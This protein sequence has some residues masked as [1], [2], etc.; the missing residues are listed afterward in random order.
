MKKTGIWI[1]KAWQLGLLMCFGCGHFEVGGAESDRFSS[2]ELDIE[3][4]GQTGFIV[5]PATETGIDFENSLTEIE[6]ARNRVLL[7]GSGVALGDFDGDGWVDIYLC[8]LNSA[9][10]LYRNLGGWRF[11]N[12]TEDAGV[13][14]DGLYCRGATMADVDGDGALDI[15]VTTVGQGTKLY[16]NQ[17][18]GRF[19]ETTREA[20]LHSDFGSSTLALADIDG[21]GT[22]DLYVSNYRSEDIRDQGRVNL[23]SRNGQLVVPDSFKQRLFLVGGQL[24]EYGEPDQLFLND[25]T[26]RFTNVDWRGGRF[27]DESGK[28]VGG[29]FPD[30]GLTASFRDVNGDL[31]PDLYVCNDYWSQD[32]FWINQGQGVFRAIA[33]TAWRSMSA[34]SMGVDFADI[35]LDGDLDFLTVDMLS[36]DPALRK[37]QKEAQDPRTVNPPGMLARPQGMRNMLFVDRGDRTY[38]EVAY[39]AGLEAS[40]WSW[41]PIFLDVDFDGDDDLLISA[42]HWRDVQDFDAMRAIQARQHSWDHI[43]DPKQLREAFAREMMIHNRL[44]PRLDMPVVAF[45]NNGK[46]RFEEVTES[47]GTEALGVRQG[48]ATGDLDNDGDLDVVA[49][50]LNGPVSVFENRTDR[51]RLSV[52]LH[53]VGSN[54]QSVG[55]VVTLDSDGMATQQREVVAGGHY[56]SGSDTRLVFAVPKG[57][58]AERLRVRWPDGREETWRGLTVNRHYEIHQAK[59]RATVSVQQERVHEVPIF[60]DVSKRLGHRHI[61][62]PFNEFVRQNL[63]PRELG[64]G[65]PGLA[66]SDLN[67]DNHLDLAVGGGQGQPVS[68]FFGNGQGQWSAGVATGT[69]GPTDLAGILVWR[70]PEGRDRLLTTV[71]G[72]ERAVRGIGKGYEISSKRV[73]AAFDF[74]SQMSS[75]GP[76][77]LGDRQGNGTLALF[78]GGGVAPGHYPRG[79]PSYL[80]DWHNDSWVVDQKN[81]VL[82]RELG[83]VNGA[84]WSDLDGD[85]YPELVLACEWGPIRVFKNRAGQLFDATESMGLSELTGWWRAVTAVDLNGDGAMDLVAS[86]WGWNSDYEASIAEPLTFFH[87]EISRPN[88]RDVIETE[89]DPLRRQRVPSR[90]LVPLATS[91]PFL[92]QTFSS[93]AEYSVASIETVL[94]ERQGLA[95]AESVTT[96]ASM[97]FLNEGDGFRPIVLPNPVQWAP[98]TGLA[99]GDFNG[100]GHEDVFMAQNYFATRPNVSRLDGGRG[101]LLLGDGT[102]DLKVVEASRSGIAAWGDQRAA[103]SGD[104]DEDGRI[105]LAVSQNRGETKLFHN[106]AGFPGLRVRLM[107]PPGNPTGLGAQLRLANGTN[108]GPAREIHGGS[109][110]WGQESAVVVLHGADKDA[111]VWVQWPGGRVANFEVPEGARELIIPF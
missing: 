61:D 3:A 98:A 59:E 5:R 42:G 89:M 8:G 30:W 37:R 22:L 58:R 15:L 38:A 31:R 88:V 83:I 104:W 21:N 111:S 2:R 23:G 75:G 95:R 84:V 107:G 36:R 82:L 77:A 110:Y 55:A 29:A 47:W 11:E 64:R 69:A 57:G 17:G 48:M 18:D 46:G 79:N 85:G 78:V 28:A 12:V 92:A 45:R 93:H 73:G 70:S 96:L 27:L 87:G 19:V 106:Q 66:L 49:N 105:D 99:R 4:T 60:A 7:N 50:R 25:G 72:Y 51:P 63:L 26:G 68:L 76:M 9:N 35:E 74:A 54:T 53:G 71:T 39:F 90:Q 81:S 97:A 103:V 10:Q 32:R 108:L 43:K 24:H 102:G 41:S 6:A 100:D 33:P 65:G 44:Y 56:L 80:F 14:C 34:S 16:R 40:D 62:P 109:G 94:G 13:G 20:G 52:A 91:L 1:T 67:G 86:N 101:A